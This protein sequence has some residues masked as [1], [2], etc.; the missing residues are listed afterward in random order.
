M[1]LLSILKN[2]LNNNSV[3]EKL[4]N[5]SVS[6]VPND[7]QAI[8]NIMDTVIPL[9]TDQIKKN[10]SDTSG[11]TNLLWALAK[12]HGGALLDKDVLNESAIQQ[13]WQKI[14]EHVFGWKQQEVIEQVS[15][16]TK[17]DKSIVSSVVDMLAPFVLDS[18][19]S[20]M[21]DTSGNSFIKLASSFLDSNKDWK[22]SDDLL[23]L[24]KKFFSR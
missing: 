5:P 24:W 18:L 21:T 17:Q 10:T 13:D 14:L 3:S 8:Q 11:L 9:F 19:W 22:I 15:Q 20:S 6:T 23:A 4:A 1:D 7:K 12:D 2:T 16:A